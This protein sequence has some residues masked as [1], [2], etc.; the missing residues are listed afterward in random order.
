MSKTLDLGCGPNPRNPFFANEVFG[1]DINNFQNQNIMVADLAVAPI[2]FEDNFFDFVTGIDFLEHIPRVVYLG[3]ERK[4]SFIDV[5]SEIWRVL[6]PNGQTFFAT[7]AYPHPEAFQDP[8]H[9]NTITENT[10]LYFSTIYQ[11][12]LELGQAY[13]FKGSFEV[14]KQTW[15]DQPYEICEGSFYNVLPYHLVWHLRAL[16]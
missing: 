7:P 9:V 1:V 10:I 13:G 3:R 12:Y 14:I 8:Q 5:M 16:K 6:K 15:A 2:P 11:S 4:Q